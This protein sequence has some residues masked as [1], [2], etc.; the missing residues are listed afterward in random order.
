MLLKVADVYDD[1]VDNTVAG[2]TSMLEPIMIV[3]LAVVVGT[4]VIA[5]SCRSSASS[6]ECN[7]KREQDFKFAVT[8]AKERPGFPIRNSKF[9]EG[10]A[11]T[12]LELLIVI[13]IIVIL[14]AL[15]LGTVGYV[16]KK[17]ARS[18]A[19]AEIAAMSAACESYK[20]DNGTYPSN[21]DTDQVDARNSTS[22]SGYQ[23]ASLYFYESLYGVA[24][25]S[26]SATPTTKSYLTFKPNMLG[27]T[28]Q[29]QNILY[30]RDPFGNSYGYSTAAQA[31]ITKGTNPPGR[32]YN[33]TFDLWSTANANPPTDQNQ[34]IKNW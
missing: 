25:G 21:A 4:I 30:I 24:S 26:R 12:I 29:T 28:D 34:W 20:A 19:E 23:L 13:S 6:V 17:A 9:R 31:D 1:E 33:P 15:I 27:P 2:L 5:S 10:P 3:F 14:A 22:P 18:R 11:F 8:R 32:G 7:S 16:Q